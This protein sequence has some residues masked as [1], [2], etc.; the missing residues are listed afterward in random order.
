MTD[1]EALINLVNAIQEV[2]DDHNENGTPINYG[3]ICSLV[4]IGHR[5][6]QETDSCN[7]N[8]KV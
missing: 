2:K 6:L 3:T 5:L 4:I 7:T 1:K 8:V